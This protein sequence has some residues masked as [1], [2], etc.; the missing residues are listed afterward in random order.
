[1]LDYLGAM[2]APRIHD[3]VRALMSLTELLPQ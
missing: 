1:V 3:T 2:T